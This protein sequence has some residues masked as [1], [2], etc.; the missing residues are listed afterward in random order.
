MKIRHSKSLLKCSA[1]VAIS[2]FTQLVNAATPG[3]SGCL[4]VTAI[5]NMIGAYANGNPTQFWILTTPTLA[6]MGCTNPV[7]FSVTTGI[8][9]VTTSNINTYLSMAL[10]AKLSGHQIGVVIDANCNATVLSLSSA[11]GAPCN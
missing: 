6:S 4:T 9:N 5:Q 3:W 2:T 8:A 1:I 7:G 10:V 11:N